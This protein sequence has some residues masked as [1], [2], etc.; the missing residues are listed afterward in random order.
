MKV[1]CINVRLAV[2]ALLA[3]SSLM[4]CATLSKSSRHE[5]ASQW[6]G[7]AASALEEGDVTGALQAL[8]TAEELSP[9][10]A[11][12]HHVRAL[13]FLKRKEL[14]SALQSVRRASELAPADSTIRTTLGKLLMDAGR[15]NEAEKAL[16]P[17]ANDTLYRD[18]YRARTNLAIIYQRKG[19]LALAREQLDRAINEA[20]TLACHA[21]FLRSQIELKAGRIRETLKD[22]GNATNKLC[23]SYAEAHLA[24]GVALTRDR[25]YERARGK[26]LEV[27]QRFKGTEFADKAVENLRYL[28]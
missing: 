8:H 9:N 26:F 22:L 19:E 18:S 13:A 4:G 11:N 16:I 5:Q 14:P 12:L 23:A 3:A 27:S 2:A 21:Y 28:P 24:V 20:P 17:A 1:P 25:Q 6:V 10:N 15:Y 7:V